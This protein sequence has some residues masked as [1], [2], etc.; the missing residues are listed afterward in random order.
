AVVRLPIRFPLTVVVPAELEGVTLIPV[1][2]LEYD[3]VEKVNEPMILLYMLTVP[4]EVEYIPIA[5]P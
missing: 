2:P 3:E 5:F 4:V 1:N